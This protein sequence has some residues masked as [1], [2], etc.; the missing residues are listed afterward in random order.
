MLFRVVLKDGRAWEGMSF[1]KPPKM[2]TYLCL[3]KTANFMS[4]PLPPASLPRAPPPTRVQDTPTKYV[5]GSHTLVPAGVPH[6]K[7]CCA[8][9]QRLVNKGCVASQALGYKIIS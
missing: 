8:K 6:I 9:A 4:S 5:A 2:V 1:A 3:L 7:S